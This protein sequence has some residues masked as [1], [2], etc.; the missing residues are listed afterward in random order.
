MTNAQKQVLKSLENVHNFL[1][2]VRGDPLVRCACAAD[3]LNHIILHHI[4]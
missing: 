1:P 4:T 2:H 3:T